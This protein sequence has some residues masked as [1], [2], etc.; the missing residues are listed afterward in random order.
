M[1]IGVATRRIIAFQQLVSIGIIDQVQVGRWSLWSS[2]A[3]PAILVTRDLVLVTLIRDACLV[4]TTLTKQIQAGSIA[5]S[6]VTTVV[7]R[8][9]D[10]R[11]SLGWQAINI[12]VVGI[13]I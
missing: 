5:D 3:Y 4:H 10:L 12:R 2:I 6:I 11:R 13:E 8:R 9:D 7:V 1:R